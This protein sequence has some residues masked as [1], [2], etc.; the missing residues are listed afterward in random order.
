MALDHFSKLGPVD[1]GIDL[2]RADVGMTQK[3]LNDPQVGA[4]HEEVGRETVAEFVRVD[5]LKA[6]DGGVLPD[7]LP[8]CDSFERAAAEGEHQ[9]TTISS[10]IESK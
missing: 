7:D 6:G 3:I 8:D 9:M 10:V 2:R 4:A 1:M 5:V